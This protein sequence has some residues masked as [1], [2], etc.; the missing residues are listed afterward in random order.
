MIRASKFYGADRKVLDEI[1]L[2]FLPGAKIG[3]LGP[4]GSGKSTLLR[5]MAG[6]EEV[7]S[8]QAAL[9]AGSTA[10]VLEQEHDHDPAKDVRTN[11]ED[12]VRHLRERL[13]RFEEISA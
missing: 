13:T 6:R 9:A 2:A 3:V 5:I 12:G 4:N 11:V 8:G 1:T 7:S 10:G